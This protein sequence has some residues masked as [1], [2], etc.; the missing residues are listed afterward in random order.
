M[1]LRAECALGTAPSTGFPPNQD[2]DYAEEFALHSSV[3]SGLPFYD[4]PDGAQ[5]LP[6]ATPNPATTLGEKEE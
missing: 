6:S 5:A 3:W 1:D 4:G 2:L